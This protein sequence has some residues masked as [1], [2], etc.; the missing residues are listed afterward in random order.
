MGSAIVVVVV[1]IVTVVLQ[2]P[3]LLISVICPRRTPDMPVTVF[4][5]AAIVNIA[6]SLLCLQLAGRSLVASLRVAVVHGAGCD[7]PAL[8]LLSCYYCAMNF[9]IACPRYLPNVDPG[10]A[11]Q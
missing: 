9:A 7:L 5:V 10:H 2:S 4:I 11:R 8:S 6:P 3:P 1:A